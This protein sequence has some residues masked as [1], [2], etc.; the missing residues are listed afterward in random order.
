MD[1]T[2]ASERGGRGWWGQRAT[3]GT[4]AR[5][6]RLRGILPTARPAPVSPLTRQTL[7]RTQPLATQHRHRATPPRLRLPTSGTPHLCVT[8][9]RDSACAHRISGPSPVHAHRASVVTSTEAAS[10]ASGRELDAGGTQPEFDDRETHLSHAG[11]AQEVPDHGQLPHKGQD[12]GEKVAAR[13][14]RHAGAGKASG[15]A[16]SPE[17]CSRQSSA[18]KNRRREQGPRR[19]THPKRLRNPNISIS[20][21]KKGYLRNTSTMPPTNAN[22]ADA[23]AVVSLAV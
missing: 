10:A 18:G 11:R 8:L 15:S 3:R 17:L 4:R 14:E 2:G 13:C 20:T 12:D 22:A 16:R 1:A 6:L 21:P 7:T 5:R 19:D 9:T 23:S